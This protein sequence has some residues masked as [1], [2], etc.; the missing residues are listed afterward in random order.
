MKY[1]ISV[2]ALLFSVS[3]SAESFR[4]VVYDIC[5]SDDPGDVMLGEEKVQGENEVYCKCVADLA[6]QNMPP[7]MQELF[8]NGTE[9]YRMVWFWNQ[10]PPLAARPCGAVVKEYRNTH[11]S[12]DQPP[13]DTKETGVTWL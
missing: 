1:L 5:N 9:N 7:E 10:F 4:D 2:A 6:S 3:A 11:R 8:L 13:S 12:V